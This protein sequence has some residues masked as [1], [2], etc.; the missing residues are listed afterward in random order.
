MIGF[1]ATSQA[2]AAVFTFY[3][4]GLSQPRGKRCRRCRFGVQFDN[5][6]RHRVRFKRTMGW[7]LMT[8]KQALTVG[9]RRPPTIRPMDILV[10]L[11]QSGQ[12]VTTEEGVPCCV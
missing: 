8:K 9:T 11:H 4:G 5:D 3:G 2:P 1:V 10:R 6:F 12:Q 7:R